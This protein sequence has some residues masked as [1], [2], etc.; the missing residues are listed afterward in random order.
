MDPRLLEER[1]V[2][3][4]YEWIK[5]DVTKDQISAVL[6]A[7]AYGRYEDRVVRLSRALRRMRQREILQE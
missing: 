1:L 2:D 4:I 6:W 3:D 5:Y 7:I